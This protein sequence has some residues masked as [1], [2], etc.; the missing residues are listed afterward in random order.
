MQFGFC[1]DYNEELFA[2]AAEA[3]FDDAGVYDQIPLPPAERSLATRQDLRQEALAA[4]DRQFKADEENVEPQYNMG[5]VYQ[6]MGQGN[7]ARDSYDRFRRISQWRSEDNPGEAA[8][9][10]DLG[11]VLQRMGQ[12]KGSARAVERAAAIDSTAYIEWARLR[13]LQGRP[14]ESIDQLQRAIGEGFRDLIILKYHPDFQSVRKDP[15]F[16]E[17]L[18]TYLKT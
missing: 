7:R 6:K 10:F 12:P 1:A 2:F 5:I 16:A 11:L 9:L 18:K 8:Y 3:G 4:F 17:L 14:N 15:R 13:S